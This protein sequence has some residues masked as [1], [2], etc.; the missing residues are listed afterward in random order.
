MTG[1]TPELNDKFASLAISGAITTADDDFNN[2][3]V[4]S[5]R[6]SRLDGSSLLNG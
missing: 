5:K 3:T 1:K 6:T 2:E 4:T